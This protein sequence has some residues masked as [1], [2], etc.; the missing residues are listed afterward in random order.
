M[1]TVRDAQKL[2]AATGPVRWPRWSPRGSIL[3][4]TVGDALVD[5]TSIEEV[6]ADGGRPHALLPGWKGRFTAAAIGLRMGNTM[7]FSPTV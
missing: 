1:P 4:F 2:A 5:G 3:R 7:F 6:S